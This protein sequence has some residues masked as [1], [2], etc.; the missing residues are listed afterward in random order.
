MSTGETSAGM[1]SEERLLWKRLGFFLCLATALALLFSLDSL[2]MFGLFLCLAGLV[3]FIAAT[4]YRKLWKLATLLCLLAIADQFSPV[5]LYGPLHAGPK[6]GRP[7][8]VPLIMGLPT[9]EIAERASRGE[10]VLGGCI[11]SGKE[12]RYVLIW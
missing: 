6:F 9:K 12:P 11:T 4:H 1:T 7:R 5:E 2:R 10:V 8:V 3:N